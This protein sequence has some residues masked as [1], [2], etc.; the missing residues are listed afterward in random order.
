MSDQTPILRVTFDE[1][2]LREAGYTD[3]AVLRYKK[4]VSE[5][6]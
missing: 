4:T 3:T 2:P 1:A 5:A 6:A